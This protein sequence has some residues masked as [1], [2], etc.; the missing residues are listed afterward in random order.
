MEQINQQG[1]RLYEGFIVEHPGLENRCFVSDPDK[2]EFCWVDY[3]PDINMETIP[4]K[5][6]KLNDVTLAVWV[7]V[8]GEMESGHFGH[9]NQ[10]E[11]RLLIRKV[12]K[13]ST[14][15]VEQYRAIHK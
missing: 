6:S 2:K 5:M 7:Q 3:A 11:K 9:L 12:I 8:E 4:K 15:P 13:W 1:N 14:S 10:Y